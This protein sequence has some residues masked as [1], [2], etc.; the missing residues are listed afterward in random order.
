MSIPNQKALAIG[1][2]AVATATFAVASAGGDL[3][4]M[5]RPSE[6]FDAIETAVTRTLCA[7]NG[8]APEELPRFR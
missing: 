1:R 3:R 6:L 5:G 4:D 2:I 8:I 7:L